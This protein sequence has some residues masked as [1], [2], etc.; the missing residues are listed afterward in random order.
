MEHREVGRSGI[1]VPRLILGAGNFG[2]VG[3]DL[4]VVGSGESKEDAFAVMDA[5]WEM[6]IDCFDT[7][8]SYGGGA[9]ERFIGRWRAAR[10][11]E[12][13]ILTSKLFH[14]RFDGD[15]GGLARDRVRRVVDDSLVALGVDRVDFYLTHEPDPNTPL[16]ETLGALD[17]LRAEGVIAAAGVSNVDGDYVR[18]CLRIADERGYARIEYVQNEYSLLARASERDVLPLCIEH[19]LG[20]A[21]FSPLAGGWLTGKYREGQPY[22]DGSR[23]T[24]RPGPYAQFTSPEVF[25]AIDALGRRARELGVSSAALAIAWALAGP[26][27]TAVVVGPRN[28]DQLDA[29]LAALEVELSEHE[30]A[31]VERL[32]P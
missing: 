23:M 7:A 3:S 24:L 25:R 17:E 8:S 21:A 32:F 15:D 9:S 4:S 27:V 31:E 22:P 1:A 14:P 29:A 19:G 2:G 26:G 5:A 30:R 10:R 13:L 20:F 16:E 12:G 18:E 6:G 11:P 28:P